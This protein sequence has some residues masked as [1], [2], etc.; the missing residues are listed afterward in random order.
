MTLISLVVTLLLY[1]DGTAWLI[2]AVISY[3]LAG[4]VLYWG[5]RKVYLVPYNKGQKSDSD[6]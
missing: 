6:A 3:I 1:F 5:N 2:P 4:A